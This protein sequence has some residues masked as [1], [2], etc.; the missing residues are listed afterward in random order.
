MEQIKNAFYE[1]MYKY[2]KSFSE[3]GV[4]ENL[5]EWAEQKSELINLLRLH[6]NWNED[7]KA[8]VIPFQEGRG[9]DREVVNEI[10]FNMMEIAE[11]RVTPESIDSFRIAFNAAISEYSSTLPESTL[12]TIRENAKIKCV[13]GEKTSRIIGKI[14]R[15]FELDHHERY[16][17]V[18]A[19][20]SDALNPIQIPRTAVLSVH[21]C[22]FLEMSNKDNTWTSCH[23]LVDGSYQ[24]GTLSYMI[25]PVSMIFFTVDPNVTECFYR[26][27][28][29]TRQMFFYKDNC[30][31][32]SR[33]YPN[34]SDEINEQNRSLIH[35]IFATCLGVPNL[36]VLKTKREDLTCIESAEESAQYA[37]Y[38]YQGNLSFFKGTPEKV[39]MIIGKK[40]ICVCCGLPFVAHRGIKCGCPDM[41]VCQDCGQTLPKN[42]T[43]YIENAYHCNACLHVCGVCGRI[44][45]DTM[46]PAYNRKGRLIEVCQECYNASQQPCFACSVR[47]VCGIIGNMFCN[48]TSIQPIQEVT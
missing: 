30:L 20:L 3:E 45:H 26:A 34:A 41:V 40:P 11:E 43:R 5:R 1:I 24:G 37:D 15:K 10:C 31:F 33:L 38:D 47:S 19:Q 17:N 18:F 32:Q 39:K 36:W 8:V 42:Q 22:D 35:K 46:Y 2:Q 48:H 9:I 4:M 25:D 44:V 27:Q 29:R 21:P 14:C 12:V 28:R 13:V 16:N 6:P 23:N 7:A